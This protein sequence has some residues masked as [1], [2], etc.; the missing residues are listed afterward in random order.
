RS[1][2]VLGRWN[3]RPRRVGRVS[4]LT[5]VGHLQVQAADVVHELAVEAEGT[6]GRELHGLRR[7]GRR[8]VVGGGASTEEGDRR[9]GGCKPTAEGPPHPYHRSTCLAHGVWLSRHG[10]NWTPSPNRITR[11]C[12]NTRG[13][14]TGN[15]SSR[16]SPSRSWVRKAPPALP[17]S[18]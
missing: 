8:L 1:R 15:Q 18:V 17:V 10:Q 7:S 11:P 14:L 4:G 9:D 6:V 2:R 16:P 3:R 5:D 12:W 13:S